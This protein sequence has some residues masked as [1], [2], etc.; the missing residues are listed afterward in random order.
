MAKKNY[1]DIEMV[2]H[3]K[4]LNYSLEK[5]KFKSPAIIYAHTTVCIHVQLKYGKNYFLFPGKAFF[6]I[7]SG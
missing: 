6:I 4:W 5:N 2:I 3:H 1:V 7:K